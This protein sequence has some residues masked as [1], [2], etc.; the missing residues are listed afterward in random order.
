M[1]TPGST[2]TIT[3]VLSADEALVAFEA[4]ALI[5]DEARLSDTDLQRMLDRLEGIL[6]TQVPVTAPN[7]DALLDE[8]KAALA[9]RGSTGGWTLRAAD[10]ASY[11]VARGV[12]HT[13]G[14]AEGS[15]V[16]LGGMVDKHHADLDFR[17]PSCLLSDAASTSGVYRNG[18]IV[19]APVAI[20]AGDELRI[21]SAV[22]IV[23]AFPSGI[24]R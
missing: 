22:L 9:A 8:A 21:G 3:I 12:L 13:V 10:G 18:A 24:R 4:L 16:R 14:R 7:Y 11:E 17:G 1:S 6:E 19:R 5:N 23:E 2:A 15:S 20:E